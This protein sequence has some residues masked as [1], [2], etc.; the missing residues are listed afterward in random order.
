MSVLEDA[1]H[2]VF[3]QVKLLI[4]CKKLEIIEWTAFC[5]IRKHQCDTT[6]CATGICLAGFSQA[7]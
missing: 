3:E 7:N 6:N 4:L 1:H 5:H 2:M